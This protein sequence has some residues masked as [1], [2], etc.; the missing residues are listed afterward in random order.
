VAFKAEDDLAS[1][2][3]LV[4][5]GHLTNALFF[6]QQAAE[7]SLK[8]FLTWHQQPFQRTHDL[9]LLA[10]KCC[11]VDPALSA[12]L[13]E[14]DTLTDYASKLRYPGTACTPG[15]GDVE[16]MFALAARIFAEMRSRVP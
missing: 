10:R 15:R 6:C 2:R 5:A 7:K 4:E 3:V 8:A 12:C 11:E 14:A 13:A 1:A 9:E 16:G